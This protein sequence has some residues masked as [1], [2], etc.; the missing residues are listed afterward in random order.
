MDFSK[1]TF[2]M[3][4]GNVALVVKKR[5]H[6]HIK[7]KKLSVNHFTRDPVIAVVYIYNIKTTSIAN[8]LKCI[9]IYC[10]VHYVDVFLNHILL[11]SSKLLQYCSLEIIH[12]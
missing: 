4:Y 7:C 1:K 3:D 10:N 8:I 11:Y 5:T 9:I 2:H 6:N 12:R